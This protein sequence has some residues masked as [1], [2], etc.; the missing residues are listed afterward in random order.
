M[1]SILMNRMLEKYKGKVEHIGS[2]HIVM[3]H[4]KH[5]QKNISNDFERFLLA[6]GMWAHQKLLKTELNIRWFLICPELVYSNEGMELAESFINRAEETLIVSKKLFE[7]I[8]DRDGPDGFVSIVQIP[9]FEINKLVLKDN[10]LI[11]ILD[12]LENPGN[13]GTILRSCDGAGVN[14][15]FVCNKKARL[16]NTK[17]LKS[18][19]GAIFTIPIMEFADTNKCIKWVKAHNFNVYL[20]DTRAD[21]TYKEFDYV[22]NTVLVV[23]SERYGIS[24]E[25]YTC[26]PQ[27]ISIPMLGACDSLNAGVAASILTYEI[28][29]KI[30][31]RRKR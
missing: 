19:M 26:N 9:N 7:K 5:I 10:A 30:N 21:K 4:I 28:S 15:V 2:Q 13:V 16:T 22:G 27:L 11:L 14:A 25:W 23:G 8:S 18:S 12:G 6:E 24:E 1:D 31:E 3:H 20:A 17:L 29:M